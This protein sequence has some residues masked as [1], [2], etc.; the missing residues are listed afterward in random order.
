MVGKWSLTPF[1]HK[2]MYDFT[3]AKRGAVVPAP[4]GRTRITIRLDD[5]ILRRFRKQVHAAGGGSCQTLIHAA[6]RRYIE[7]D[8]EPL[9]ETLIRV[10]REKMPEY[11]GR[12]TK[13][14][15]GRR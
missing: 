8:Q 3:Q 5:D 15:S 11:G 7:F 1:F 10:I 4:P 9:K 12:H 2:R 13:R 6:L 14:S